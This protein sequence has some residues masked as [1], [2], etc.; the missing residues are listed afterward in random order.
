MKRNLLLTVAAAGLWLL[1]SAP[2]FA[3][4]P[5]G[6]VGTQLAA[7]LWTIKIEGFA[8]DNATCGTSCP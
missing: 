5:T 3:V 2:A 1:A 4:C 8:V 7:G 6:M